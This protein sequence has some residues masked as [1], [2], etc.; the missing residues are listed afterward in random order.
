MEMR[1]YPDSDRTIGLADEA[2]VRS[3]G[4]TA[5]VEAAG[6]RPSLT[7]LE[8]QVVAAAFSDASGH[9]CGRARK[10]SRLASGFRHL[11]EAVTGLKGP[12]PLADPRLEKL[13]FFL[14]FT[15]DKGRP[16]QRIWQEL[17]ELGFSEAQ[18]EALALLALNGARPRG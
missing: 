16:S 10:P 11:L 14:C 8:W 3:S 4:T 15:R 2:A 7:A 18:V 9:A 12:Q 1:H 5:L 6:A 17:I 13:R